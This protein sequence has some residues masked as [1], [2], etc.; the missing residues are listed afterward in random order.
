M[1]SNMVQ[2]IEEWQPPKDVH[3]VQSFL[4]LTNSY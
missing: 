4:R 1:D 2:N 3:E